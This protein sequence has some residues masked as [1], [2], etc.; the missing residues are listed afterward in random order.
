MTTLPETPEGERLARVE[1]SVEALVREVSDTK[2]DVRPLRTMVHR[3][4]QC[5]IGLMF[6]TL[7][8]MWVSLI[9]VTVMRT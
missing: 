6:G 5:T 8:P 9:V 3:N 1:A 2:E 4:F 7:I